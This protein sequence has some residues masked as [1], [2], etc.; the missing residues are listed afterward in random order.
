MSISFD[1][2]WWQRWLQR[3]R[4]E[5][6]D[7]ITDH[8]R[9]GQLTGSLPAI[10]WDHIDWDAYLSTP[11]RCLVKHRIEVYSAHGGERYVA[12]SDC[13]QRMFV[14]WQEVQ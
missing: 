13:G 9:L 11:Q 14:A 10:V 5:R 3:A 4:E 2:K 1:N 8:A 6:L 12:C 7:I